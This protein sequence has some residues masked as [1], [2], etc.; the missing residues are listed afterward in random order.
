MGR[1]LWES[2]QCTFVG[3]A[4]TVFV[5]LSILMLRPMKLGQ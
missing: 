2:V 5:H 4:L 3:K 1:A